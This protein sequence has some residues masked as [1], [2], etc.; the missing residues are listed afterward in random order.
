ME[1]PPGL[2]EKNGNETP[3]DPRRG[4]INGESVYMLYCMHLVFEE[5]VYVT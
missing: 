5:S 1:I 4:N 2:A 3:G